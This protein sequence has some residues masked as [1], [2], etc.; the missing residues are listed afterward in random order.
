MPIGDVKEHVES[1]DCW[2]G[3]NVDGDVVVHNSLDRREDFDDLT[4]Q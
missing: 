2:C 3:P 4:V 1:I